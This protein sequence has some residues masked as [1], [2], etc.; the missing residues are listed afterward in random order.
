MGLHYRT[1]IGLIER[2]ELKAQRLGR[3]ALGVRSSEV[4]RWLASL[5]GGAA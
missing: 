4:A 3:R 2:G 5:N 1:V